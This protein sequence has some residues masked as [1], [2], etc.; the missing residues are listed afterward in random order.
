[1]PSAMDKRAMISNR[2]VT[3]EV[4]GSGSS[5]YGQWSRTA[6]KQSKEHSTVL[7]NAT[8]AKAWQRGVIQV[9]DSE[10]TF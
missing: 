7:I 5:S 6:V 1:M 9:R 2:V 8:D 4:A 3:G 10:R